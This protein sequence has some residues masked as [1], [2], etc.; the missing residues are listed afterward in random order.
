MSMITA[1]FLPLYRFRGPPRVNAYMIQEWWAYLEL[2]QGPRPYQG[3]ALT[4]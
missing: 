3:R 1:E 4:N 2:N